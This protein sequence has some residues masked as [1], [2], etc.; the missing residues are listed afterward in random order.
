LHVSARISPSFP[1][2]VHLVE[3]TEL[4]DEKLLAATVAASL[5]LREATL[6]LQQSRPQA[7]HL[8]VTML[9]NY[10]ANKRALLVLDGCE[11]VRDAC[12]DLVQSLLAAA[13][14]LHI[15]TTSRP[16]LGLFGECVRV[17]PPLPVPALGEPIPVATLPRYEAVKLFTLRAA[18]VLPAAFS[19]RPT[20]GARRKYALPSA[21]SCSG[22]C[23]TKAHNSPST[24]P[25]PLR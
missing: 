6:A 21:T 14:G 5:G 8:P 1:D 22:A 4:R 18:A 9:A 2:G 3:L 19:P 10:F 7:A 20:S 17:V 13:P 11:H 24:R 15:L 16:A 23:C 12:A 25:S